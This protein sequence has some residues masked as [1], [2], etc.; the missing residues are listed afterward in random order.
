MFGGENGFCKE[1]EL[2]SPGDH[3][4][5]RNDSSR[6]GILTDSRRKQLSRQF[7]GGM[8]LFVLPMDYLEVDL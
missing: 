2:M 3:V 4:R 8:S 5:L 6:I 7:N 1:M